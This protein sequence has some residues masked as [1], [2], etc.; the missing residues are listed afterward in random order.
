M[1]T[2]KQ[3]IKLVAPLDCA[4]GKPPVIV[5]ARGGHNGELP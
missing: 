2:R 5:K 1:M 4:C 3:E